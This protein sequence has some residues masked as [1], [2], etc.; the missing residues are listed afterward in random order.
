MMLAV[1]IPAFAGTPE[2]SMNITNTSSHDRQGE[3]VEISDSKV[4]A[5]KDLP[6]SVKDIDGMSVPSQFTHDGSL[7]IFGDFPAHQTIKF[8]VAACSKDNPEGSD[9][10]CVGQIRHDMQD[11]YTWEND[12]GGYRLYGP[13]YRKGG[14][15]VS[16]YDIWTKS[17]DYPVL[18]QRYDGHMKF[19][20]SYHKDFGS[21]MDV[22]TVGPTLGA[23]MNALIS[24]DSIYYPV[25]YEK[26]EI[27]DNGPLRVTA[28]I[29]C[30]PEKIGDDNEVIETRF[31]RLDRGDWLNRTTVSYEGLKQS[32]PITT[33][34]VVHKQNKQ[35][36]AIDPEKRYLAY[37]DLTDNPNNGNGAIF[38][39]IVNPQLPD[40]ISYVAFE[41][42]I[43]D[44]VGQIQTFSTYRPASDY[45]YY[46]GA[47]W[48]KGGVKGMDAWLNY[49]SNFY[50]R[51]RNPLKIEID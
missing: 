13:S 26:C 51:L 30:Y 32:H 31:I 7:L 11:D 20:M 1:S 3:V 50:E 43:A 9:T 46:W 33:G 47:G 6:I 48:S 45:T 23:G 37:V 22:Y 19:G 10:I 34:I 24:G 35:A 38:I 36:Y 49:L 15:K 29:T 28:K 12:R 27:L 41:K 21:G 4:R 5:L 8:T 18:K 44:G 40:S 17:V 2:I 14:G 42:E 16:G 39:G 25:A